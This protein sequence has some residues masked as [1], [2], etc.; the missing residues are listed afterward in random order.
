MR[1]ARPAVM[2]DVGGCS[3]LV[4]NGVQGWIVPPQ[5]P[6][7]L[8]EALLKTIENP[9]RRVAMGLAARERVRHEF[10][11]ETLTA[12]YEALYESIWRERRERRSKGWA[13]MLWRTR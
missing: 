11:I 5:Q 6:V 2:T 1:A 8:A 9:A 4:E 10:A 7:A 13:T 3:E 12:Q